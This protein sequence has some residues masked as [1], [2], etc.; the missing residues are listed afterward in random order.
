[1]KRR[2]DS[3]FL[4]FDVTYVDGTQ[5]SRRKIASAALFEPK[6]DAEV[7]AAIEAQD[8]EI[9][10]ASGRPRGPIKSVARSRA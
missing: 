8:R 2:A 10:I 6:D 3:S 9:A 1:M 4:L 7:K 5:S